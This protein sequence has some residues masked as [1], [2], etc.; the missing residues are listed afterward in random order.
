MAQRVESPLRITPAFFY[1]LLTLTDGEAH[2]YAMAREVEERSGGAISLGP[3]SLYWSLGRLAETGL[4]EE[5]NG[6]HKEAG[7]ERRRTYRL[8]A[9]GRDVLRAHAET[10]DRALEYARSRNLL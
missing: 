5:T 9:R 2:G 6:P 8:T 10:L 7:T 3:G 4:I 1:L